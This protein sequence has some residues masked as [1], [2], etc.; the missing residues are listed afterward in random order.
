[1]PAPDFLRA[2]RA[3]ISGEPGDVRHTAFTTI[4]TF[5]RRSAKALPQAAMRQPRGVQ[6]RRKGNSEFISRT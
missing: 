6:C 3:I 1:M 5:T 4:L 2:A